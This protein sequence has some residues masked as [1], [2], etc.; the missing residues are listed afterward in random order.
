MVGVITLAVTSAVGAQSSAPVPLSP[1]PPDPKNAKELTDELVVNAM[2]K[3]VDYLFTQRKGNN[4]ENKLVNP[5]DAWL[6]LSKGTRHWGGETALVAYALLHVG[7]SMED[8]R[9]S[10]KSE[11]LA[12]V[13]QWLTELNV[14]ATYTAGLHASALTLVPRKPNIE[15]SLQRTRTYLLDAIGPLGGY[16]YANHT[17]GTATAKFGA[18]TTMVDL[19]GTFAR[20]QKEIVAGKNAFETAGKAVGNDPDKLKLAVDAYDMV[21]RKAGESLRRL[22][23]LAA[24]NND[25]N[26]VRKIKPDHDA[27]I[28]EHRQLLT[29]LLTEAQR[30]NGKVATQDAKFWENMVKN[31]NEDARYFG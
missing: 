14:D 5:T 4:F 25:L 13:I 20:L 3:G 29:T 16:E 19:P 21:L 18:G 30:T 26:T 6:D 24:D 12:P 7:Q 10:Y 28:A 17:P 23:S 9:L 15:A 1:T 2:R 8:P 27:V 31:L 11:E 22:A